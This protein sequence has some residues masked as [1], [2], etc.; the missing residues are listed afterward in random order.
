MPLSEA[1]ALFDSKAF[2]DWRKG[3]EAKINLGVET[4]NRLN[5][6]IKGLNVLIAVLPKAM[7]PRRK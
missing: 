2:T 7:N 3:E 5:N 6:V 1:Q 4:V